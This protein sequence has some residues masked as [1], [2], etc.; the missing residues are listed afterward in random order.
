[1]IAAAFLALNFYTYHFFATAAVLPQRDPLDDFPLQ[2]GDWR[3]DTPQELTEAII[4]NLGVTDYRICDYVRRAPWGHVNLYLGYHASQVRREGGGSGENSIHPPEHCIPGSG[5]DI[6]DRRAIE[7][8]LPGLPQRP[9]HV[10]R[11]IIAKGNSRQ[12][13]YYW[14]Q[15]RGRVIAEGWKKIAGV[16]WDRAVRHRTDGS[17]VRFTIPVR[18]D[19]AE[20]AEADFREVANHVVPLLPVYIPN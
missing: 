6:I 1:V 10:N 11:L 13:V 5:W 2:L 19:D 17:L 18:N 9:A 16:F 4:D 20:A 8:D 14:Y 3:C 12:L 7:L 15:S